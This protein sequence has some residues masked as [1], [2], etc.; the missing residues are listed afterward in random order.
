MISR[1]SFAMFASYN[2]DLTKKITT[3]TMT[4]FKEENLVA[5]ASI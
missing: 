4:F 5:N 3:V 1:I 2:F